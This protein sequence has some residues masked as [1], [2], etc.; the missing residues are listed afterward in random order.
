MND[1]YRRAILGARDIFMDDMGGILFYAMAL[2]K[3]VARIRSNEVQDL[4]AFSHN[5]VNSSKL[6]P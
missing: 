2:I 1:Q 3:N 4:P 6:A 5:G